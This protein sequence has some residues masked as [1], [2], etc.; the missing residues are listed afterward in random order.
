[1]CALLLA[2]SFRAAA[3]LPSPVRERM[4][5][6]GIPEGAMGVIVQ[7]LSDGAILLSH[8]A[9]RSLQPASTMKLVTSVAALE[10]LGPAFRGRTE[11]LSRGEPV[12]P[13]S[14]MR[15]ACRRGGPRRPPTSMSSSAA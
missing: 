8:G 9:E 12:D 1:M 15:S 6:A 4:R 7:R 10:T 2:L 5:A 14:G 11:L 13:T 3:E